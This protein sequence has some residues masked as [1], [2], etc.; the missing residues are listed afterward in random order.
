MLERELLTYQAK[1]HVN[2]PEV[3]LRGEYRPTDGSNLESE[4]LAV[5]ST[6]L[7]GHFDLNSYLPNIGDGNHGDYEQESS[8]VGH[9]L[10]QDF[11]LA[12]PKHFLFFLGLE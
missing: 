9:L 2:V 7:L 5:G 6:K 8:E 1:H 10:R 3:A 12:E 11:G 4:V